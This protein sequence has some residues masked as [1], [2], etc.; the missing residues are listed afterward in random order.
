[1]NKGNN[2]FRK[3]LFCS[4]GALLIFSATSC[5]SNDKYQQRAKERLA[6]KELQAME[7]YNRPKYL[8]DT[9][10]LEENELTDGRIIFKKPTQAKVSKVPQDPDLPKGDYDYLIEGKSSLY[11]IVVC[12]YSETPKI[13]MDDFK[14]MAKK[15]KPDWAL[16]LKE[17]LVSI[18]D[19]S[20]DDQQ[21]LKRK[22][23]ISGKDY[24]TIT[25]DFIVI[26]DSATQKLCILSSFATPN[27]ESVVGS[28]MNSLKFY[29]LVE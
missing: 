9:A 12:S 5:T 14:E 6:E 26:E 19:N 23:R 20:T 1:M 11:D 8:I 25:W 13:T 27:T 4:F 16:K 17:V 22:S 2:I 10:L 3:I 18:D 15:W 7:D 24:K 28:V 29:N 21:I